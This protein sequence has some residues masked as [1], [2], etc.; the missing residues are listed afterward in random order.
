MKFTA[1]RS[2]TFILCLPWVTVHGAAWTTDYEH[3]S[4]R[5]IA[6]YDGVAFKTRIERFN[7][8]IVFDPRQID[9]ARFDVSVDISSMNSNSTDR[10]EGMLGKE[11]FDSK[12]FPKSH[13]ISTGFSKTGANTFEM[14]GQLTV[15][16]ITKEITL[17]FAWTENTTGAR[18]I[19]QT[20]LQRTDFKIGTG[21]WETDQTIGFKVILEVDLLLRRNP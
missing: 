16:D 3:S 10:D 15:K 4:L 17:P 7:A 9:N 1:W 12:A 5:F 18:M 14:T 21:E 8:Q 11:W 19:G 6:T 2:I 20:T 13:F